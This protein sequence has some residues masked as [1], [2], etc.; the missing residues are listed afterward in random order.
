MMFHVV[1]FVHIYM[2]FLFGGFVCV[3]LCCFSCAFYLF[4]FCFVLCVCDFG[5]ILGLSQG[6]FSHLRSNTSRP[7]GA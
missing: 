1:S 6:N 7:V 4:L 3:F 2:K 5:Q